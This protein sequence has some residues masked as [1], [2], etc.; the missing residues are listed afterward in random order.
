MDTGMISLAHPSEDTAA[1]FIHRKRNSLVHR[2][3]ESVAGKQPLIYALQL[4][5]MTYGGGLGFTQQAS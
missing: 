4:W 3:A 1:S 2:I 5:A